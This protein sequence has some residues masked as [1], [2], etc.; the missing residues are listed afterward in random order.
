MKNS[1]FDS[2]FSKEKIF[3]KKY[4]VHSS[5]LKI[6]WSWWIIFGKIIKHEELKKPKI[7]TEEKSIKS[8]K[9]D[10]L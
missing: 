2:N 4:D 10:S 5:G 9:L 1:N 3:Q 8:I 7:I 6:C